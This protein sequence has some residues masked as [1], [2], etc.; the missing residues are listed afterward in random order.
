[1]FQKKNVGSI[2]NRVYK[3][4]HYTIKFVKIKGITSRHD[5]KQKQLHLNI[6]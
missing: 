1:M 4:N 6:N 5:K 2:Y 3:S